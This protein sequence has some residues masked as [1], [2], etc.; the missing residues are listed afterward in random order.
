MS[1]ENRELSS[2]NVCKR[3]NNSVGTGLK[4]RKCGVVSHKSCLK[5]I[6]AKFYEDSTVDCCVNNPVQA[7]TS[8]TTTAESVNTTMDVGKTVEQ[9]KIAYLEEIIRQKDLVIK[10]QSMLID[11][12]QV[13]IAFLN[14]DLSAKSSK[15]PLTSNTVSVS[16]VISTKKTKPVNK[17]ESVEQQNTVQITPAAVSRAIHTAHTTKVC[18]EVVNLTSDIPV[19]TQTHKNKRKLLVGNA[20]DDRGNLNLKSA[21][22]TKMSHF[23]ITNC[24]PETTL[25]DFS[26]YLKT[27]LP[28]TQVEMLKSRNPLQYSSFKISVPT[29]D[30]PKILKSELW[31]SG[32]VINKFFRSKIQNKT[33]GK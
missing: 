33:D 17:K 27:I 5:T 16:D 25:E 11:S 14:R 9:I 22:I 8:N 21:K 2:A 10:N 19:I 23:H 12:L 18:Q 32:V 20:D 15:V 13:Q 26:A 7:K 3:C 1:D 30:V 4:C 24:D 6:K 31:P 29:E 28:L